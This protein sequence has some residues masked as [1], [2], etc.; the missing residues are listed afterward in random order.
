MATELI[1]YD[2]FELNFIPTHDKSKSKTSIKTNNFKI[3]TYLCTIHC[4]KIH[5]QGKKK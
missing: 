3:T 2:T 4:L 1:S 5:V